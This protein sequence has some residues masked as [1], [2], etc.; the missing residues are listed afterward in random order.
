MITINLKNSTFDS[1]IQRE[2]F[3]NYLYSYLKENYNPY[4]LPPSQN[5]REGYDWSLTIIEVRFKKMRIPGPNGQALLFT[6][7]DV[8][9]SSQFIFTD[10][11]LTDILNRFIH[12]LSSD[13]GNKD[14]IFIL[15]RPPPPPAQSVNQVSQV[16]AVLSKLKEIVSAED[17][18]ETGAEEL[19][20][21]IKE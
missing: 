9:F 20:N 16:H 1:I 3:I 18:Q 15:K 19:F 6:N 5:D 13:L 12:V 11:D 14:L 10:P 2:A 4:I 21:R 17:W 8:E 7:N